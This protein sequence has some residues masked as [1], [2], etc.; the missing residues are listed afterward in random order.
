MRNIVTAGPPFASVPA[1]IAVKK[2]NAELLAEIN[3][4]VA[5]LRSNGTLAQIQEQWRSQEMLFM[6]RGRLNGML[7]LAMAPCSWSCSALAG[8]LLRKQLRI[9]AERRAAVAKAHLLARALQSANDCISITDTSDR[10]LYVNERSCGR[11]GTMRARTS[12]GGTSHVV[13]AFRQS[14]RSCRGDR[15]SDEAGRLAR[16]HPEPVEARTE[17]SPYR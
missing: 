10:I 5:R 3:R 15:D 6:S 9:Q 2:G 12:S 16:R 11:T 14:S 1:G 17:S 4:G 13:R 7:A 8:T